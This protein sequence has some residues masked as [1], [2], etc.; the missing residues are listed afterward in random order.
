MTLLEDALGA[1]GGTDRWQRL[2]RFTVHMSI[3]GPLLARRGKGGLLKE[4]VVEGCTHTQSL[5][6]TGFGAPDH[7]G[8]YQPE[9]VAIERLDGQLLQERNNPRAAF[10][11]QGD[12][13]PWDDLHLAYF[14]GCSVWHCLTTPFLLAQT[15]VVTEE[16]P[17][18]RERGEIWRRL[19]A[20]FPPRI[21]THSSEQIFY[22]DAA[23]L[24][25]RVDHGA[26]DA[27]QTQVANY[28]SAHQAFSGIVVPTLRRSQS[29]ESDG[30]RTVGPVRVDIE[31]FDASFA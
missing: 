18:W 24:Q 20:V 29:L 3:D 5:C 17:S 15:D 21:A 1:C 13:T 2:K 27:A 31:I 7:R 26:I 25:R 10:I 30:A 28:C 11:G 12:H 22:F 6:M 19:R 9:R 4:I 16:L 8:V 23:G 14:C